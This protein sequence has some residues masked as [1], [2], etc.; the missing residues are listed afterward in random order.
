ML[1]GIVLLFAHGFKKKN[2]VTTI[3][4]NN[5]TLLPPALGMRHFLRVLPSVKAL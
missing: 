1:G 2:G 5:G 3:D 4:N